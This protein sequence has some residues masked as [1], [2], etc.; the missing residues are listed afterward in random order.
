MINRLNIELTNYCNLKCRWCG[1]AG[2]REKG[3]MDFPTFKTVMEEI[4]SYKN[5]LVS[6][7]HIYNGVGESL[8][9]PLFCDFINLL[10]NLNKRPKCVLVTNATLLSSELIKTIISSGGVDVI[11][12]SID[13]GTP[14]SYEWLRRG[15][16][17]RTTIANV[18][19]FLSENQGT[20]RTGL[21]TIDLNIDFCD[22][23]L[24]LTKL[25]DFMDIRPPHNWTG[26]E[27]LEN[28]CALQPNPN[29]CWHIR[30]N[31]AILWNGDISPC[32][33]DQYG[34]CI[35]GNIKIDCINKIWRGER[36]KILELQ[37]RGEKNKIDL[38]RCCSIK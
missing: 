30:N 3:F 35:I 22:E 4:N 38:C 12:F 27:K 7:I 10:G 21:I 24:A 32:C 29:P 17:W 26:Q 28:M 13:G 14:N 16:N 34:R 19:N 31:L 6:E 20:I 11:Q 8:L 9:H 1:G 23:F 2:D 36:E 37:F 25:V 5:L 33:N 18:K 15:A